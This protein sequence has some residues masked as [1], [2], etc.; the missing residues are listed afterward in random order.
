MTETADTPASPDAID[1]LKTADLA[2]RCRHLGLSMAEERVVV[3]FFGIGHTVHAGTGVLDADGRP[4]TPAVAEVIAAYLLDA[5]RVDGGAPHRLVSFREFAGAGP[6]VDRFSDNT[7]KLI[8]TTFS[9]RMADL[10]TAAERLFG[11]PAGGSVAMDL[12]LAFQA[13]PG[14]PMYLGFNDAEDGLPAQCQLFFRHTA[15]SYLGLRHRFALGTY[16]AGHLIH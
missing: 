2:A 10:L 14:V 5:A 15:E 12:F 13:L 7:G 4:P 6:L 3:T 8:A 11:Q 1:R 9:G 16:L